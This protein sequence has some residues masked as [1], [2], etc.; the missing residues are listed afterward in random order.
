M[1]SRGT[2]GESALFDLLEKN[3]LRTGGSGCLEYEGS[4]DEAICLDGDLS[5]RTRFVES[6]K[7][8]HSDGTE[9]VRT[10]PP[11]QGREGECSV[12]I[13]C[14]FNDGML[15][16]PNV[17]FRNG[18]VIP[19]IHDTTCH[20]TGMEPLV[21]D[22]ENAAG[23]IREKDKNKDCAYPRCRHAK[24]AGDQGALHGCTVIC[25]GPVPGKIRRTPRRYIPTLFFTSVPP[26]LCVKSFSCLCALRV[27]AGD[28]PSVQASQSSFS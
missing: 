8:R 12:G 18:M 15:L 14:R 23:E 4:Y 6:R 5:G 16:T 10:M 11:V 27:F 19:G 28:P 20:C 22:G 2:G 24:C 21:G 9:K 25:R 13:G 1:I 17:C 3:I 7:Q 26:R